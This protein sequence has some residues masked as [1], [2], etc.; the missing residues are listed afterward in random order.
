MSLQKAL[1][2][3][4]VMCM[5]HPPDAFF[6][7]SIKWTTPISDLPKDVTPFTGGAASVVVIDSP[8]K[9]REVFGTPLPMMGLG[10]V[11][12]VRIRARGGK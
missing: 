9:A 8:Q 12:V 3:A 10:K 6:F 4:S 2:C 11:K 5:A 1:D 7:D